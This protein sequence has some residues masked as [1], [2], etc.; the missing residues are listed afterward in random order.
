MSELRGEARPATEHHG[1]LVIV[2]LLEFSAVQL[3]DAAAEWEV[4]TFNA[5]RLTFNAQVKAMGSPRVVT[6]RDER[7]TYS[8]RGKAT[9]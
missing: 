4:V 9:C 2:G 1:S 8:S 7:A 3:H 5:Q 6:V